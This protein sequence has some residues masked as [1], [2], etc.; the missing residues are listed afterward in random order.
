MH[1]LS[2][3]VNVW[4]RLRAWLVTSACLLGL[5][6]TA[7]P[8]PAKTYEAKV[9]LKDGKVHLQT[10]AGAVCNGLGEQPVE[11]PPGD[12]DVSGDKADTFVAALNQALGD[13][14]RVKVKK[15][16]L[17]V[18]IDTD[19]LPKDCDAGKR[20]VRLFAAAEAVEAAAAQGRSFHY[21][22]NLPAPLDPNRPV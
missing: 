21:G 6:L 10:L 12:L 17:V 4:S 13:G 9:P 7:A 3:G 20:A 1:P 22:L 18:R 8:A 14:C 2:F 19:K 5:L 15:D 16:S 11:T